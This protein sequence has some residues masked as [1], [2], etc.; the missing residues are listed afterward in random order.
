M[1]KRNQDNT[2]AIKMNLARRYITS[3]RAQEVVDAWIIELKGKNYIKYVSET[4][5]K[6]Y[7][8]SKKEVNKIDDKS[9]DPFL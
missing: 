9:W 1:G 6:T 2:E 3:S 7:K 4:A 8:N 5:S